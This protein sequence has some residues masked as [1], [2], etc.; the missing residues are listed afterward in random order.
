MLAL[1]AVN[2]ERSRSPKLTA[3][4]CKSQDYHTSPN[5]IL[6]IAN[7]VDSNFDV[8]GEVDDD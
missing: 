1:A 2:G 8:G 7:Q 4:R 6:L 5:W 3:N